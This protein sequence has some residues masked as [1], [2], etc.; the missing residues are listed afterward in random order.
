MSPTWSGRDRR[1]Q[2]IKTK[3]TQSYP[4]FSFVVC[5]LVALRMGALGFTRNSVIIFHLSLRN[6]VNTLSSFVVFFSF[7]SI[8]TPPAFL[9]RNNGERKI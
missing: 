1:R 7:L 6:W 9:Q 3:G 4:F 8:H 2:K 5:Y